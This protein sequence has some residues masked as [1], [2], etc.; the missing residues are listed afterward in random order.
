MLQWVY[1]K[2]CD[3]GKELQK[4]GHSRPYRL[5]REGVFFSSLSS[6]MMNPSNNIR[7]LF[8]IQGNDRSERCTHKYALAA[9]KAHLQRSQAE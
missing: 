7:C 9:S 5:N 6:L 3:W 2:T 1:F 8:T 4:F